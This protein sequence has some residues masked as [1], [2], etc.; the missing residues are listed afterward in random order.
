MQ[1]TKQIK[2]GLLFREKTALFLNSPEHPFLRNHVLND[3]MSGLKAFSID[4]D[5]RVIYKETK[6][7]YLFYDIGNHDEVYG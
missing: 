1:N 3:K 4:K 7:Y 2:L 5:C 6:D